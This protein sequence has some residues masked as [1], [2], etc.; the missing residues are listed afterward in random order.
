[1]GTVQPKGYKGTLLQLLQETHERG[2]SWAGYR[3]CREEEG[4][5][6]SPCPWI[7]CSAAWGHAGMGSSDCFLSNCPEEVPWKAAVREESDTAKQPPLRCIWETASWAEVPLPA[8][9]LPAQR[10][11]QP[12]GG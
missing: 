4:A 1:M 8:T 12:S 11:E 3:A 10:W 6:L 5:A 9:S 7:Q 2:C